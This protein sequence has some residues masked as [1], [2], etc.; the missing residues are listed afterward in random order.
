MLRLLLAEPEALLL[1]EPFNKLDTVLRADFR[2]F[3]FGHA[4]AAGLPVL[5]V[6]HDRADAE[7]A[8]GPVLKL[9]TSADG[10][11]EISAACVPPA[12]DA[13]RAAVPSGEIR[14]PSEKGAEG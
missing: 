5:M 1:D 12:I 11:P 10:A 4:V 14:S 7:A 3:V 2:R 9:G 8:N 13:V 6:T